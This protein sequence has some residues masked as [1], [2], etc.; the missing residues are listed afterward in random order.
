MV[1]ER[2]VVGTISTQIF[3]T[4]RP[5]GSITFTLISLS[6]FIEISLVAQPCSFR[7]NCYSFIVLNLPTLL[8]KRNQLILP[9]SKSYKCELPLQVGPSKIGFMILAANEFYCG[10]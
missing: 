1:E 8:E 5:F 2:T 4:G 3:L 10:F 7:R 9:G 6:F